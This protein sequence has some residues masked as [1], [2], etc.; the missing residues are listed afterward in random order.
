VRE[1]ERRLRQGDRGLLARVSRHIPR[2][3]K[4][5]L[6]TQ[7]GVVK[8]MMNTQVMTYLFGDAWNTGGRLMSSPKL[9]AESSAGSRPRSSTPSWTWW[10]A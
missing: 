3:P 7:A 5:H 10:R 4:S 1:T 8:V 2:L 9:K 6:Q